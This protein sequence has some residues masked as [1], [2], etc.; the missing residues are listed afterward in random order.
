MAGTNTYSGTTTVS[1][2]MLQFAQPAALYNGVTGS[3]TAA[4]ITAGSLATLAVN[5]DSTAGLPPSQA[6]T[7]FANLTGTN[8]GLLAGCL[9]R[10]RH[11]ERHRAG[12]LLHPASG[13]GRRLRRLY[14]VGHGDLEGHQCLQQLYR[15]HDRRQWATDALRRQYRFTAPG[16]VTVSN[17][18]SGGLSILSLLNHNALGSGGTDGDLAP[19]SLNS[20]GGGTAILEIGATR[21]R[22]Q[23]SGSTD[24]SYVV[25]PAGQMPT[26]GQISLGSSGNTADVV[27]F[28]A[29]SSNYAPRTVALYT[30]AA[31]TTLQTLQFGTYHPRQPGARFVGRQH[32][33]DPAES[34]RPEFERR[35]GPACSFRRFAGRLRRC[36]RASMRERS[37]TR[38]RRPST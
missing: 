27:G 11:H 31:L 30:T 33:A 5:V 36:L 14:Q 10:H 9:L 26:A 3:W 15:P 38:V 34:D 22:P 20:T 24:F 25:V 16:L 32:D 29:S 2:G 17:S 23:P 4:N 35:P 21:P 18:T 8:S 7:L 19:I 1:G 28:S 37:A 6:G 12:G 13:L